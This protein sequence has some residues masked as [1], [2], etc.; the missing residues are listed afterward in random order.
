MPLCL[1]GMGTIKLTV[2]FPIELEE[3][4]TGPVQQPDINPNQDL[5]GQNLRT[6]GPQT[7]PVILTL[8]VHGFYY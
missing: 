1:T 7:T 3:S 8:H 2:L 5:D 4:G 6:K